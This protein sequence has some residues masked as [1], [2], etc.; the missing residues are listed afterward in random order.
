MTLMRTL[1]LLALSYAA[2]LL[3]G[4]LL[5]VG[6]IRSPLLDGMTI[7]F[8][9]GVALAFIGALFLLAIGLAMRSRLPTDPATLVG[10]VAL[11][12][13]FN[14]CFLVIFP[15]TFDRSISMF[16]LARIEQADGRLD[17]KALQ[18][19]FTREYLGDMHQ[20]DRRVF[21]QML[22]GNIQVIDGRIHLTPRGKAL[23]SSARAVGDWFGAD[24][25]FVTP[26]AR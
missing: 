6:L 3:L 8:Y 5:Y 23:L 25:R 20:I 2:A 10:A 1:A 7:L 19:L 22:S 11:S 18:A 17:S 14:L 15:V 9:R 13:A 26:A 4:F 16:L 12:L 24:P 21:E